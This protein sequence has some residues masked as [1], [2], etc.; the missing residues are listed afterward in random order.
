MST[1]PPSNEGQFQDGLPEEVV[2]R[3]KALAHQVME[4]RQAML[5]LIDEKPVV[6][7]AAAMGGIMGATVSDA[8]LLEAIVE[9]FTAN[10]TV[11]HQ[12]TFGESSAIN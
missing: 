11:V 2:E 12:G 7:V 10:F 4:L 5:P 1:E 8:L 9:H 3:A 6:V